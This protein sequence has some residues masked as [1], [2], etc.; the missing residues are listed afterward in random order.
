[1][2][3]SLL[4]CVCESFFYGKSWIECLDLIIGLLFVDKSDLHLDN[5]Y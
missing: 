5:Y 3:P 4:R 1:M 2:G